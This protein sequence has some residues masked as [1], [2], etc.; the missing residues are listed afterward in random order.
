MK[1]ERVVKIEEQRAVSI[2]P[3]PRMMMRESVQ[4]GAGQPP[5]EAGE[6]EIR[7]SVTLTATVR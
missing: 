6:I 1:V 7:A 5:M 3:Q 4:G 2:P